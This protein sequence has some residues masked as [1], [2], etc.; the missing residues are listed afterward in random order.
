MAEVA[1]K[2]GS[3]TFTNLNA[4]VKSWNLDGAMDMLPT[5]DYDDDGH[6]TFIGGCDGWTANCELN[7]DATNTV[8]LGDSATLTLLIGT[9]TPKYAGTALVASISVSSVVDGLVTATISFQGTGPYTYT[10]A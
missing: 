1:G 10:A 8:A 6:K 5:T 4:G 7:W 3:A 2:G 9:A